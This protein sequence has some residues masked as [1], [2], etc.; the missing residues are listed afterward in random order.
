MGKNFLLTLNLRFEKINYTYSKKNQYQFL[1]SNG[2]ITMS[3]PTPHPPTYSEIIEVILDPIQGPLS[4]YWLA[5]QILQNR[6]SKAKNP[7]KAALNQIQQERGRLLVYLQPD[8]ILPIRLALQGARFRHRLNHSIIRK[9]LLELETNLVYYLPRFFPIEQIKL[10]DKQKTPIPFELLSIPI[11]KNSILGVSEFTQKKA[12]LGR[13]LTAQNAHPKDHL[14]FTLLDWENGVFQLD[15]EPAS[16][17]DRSLLKERNQQLADIFWNLLEGEKY[18]D[19]INYVAVPSAY[20][21]LPDKGG[22]PRDHW[23]VV[24]ENDER[25]VT[26]GWEIRYS[27]AQLP[28]PELY[29]NQESGKRVSTETEKFT[30]QQ[31]QQ[32]YRLKIALVYQ[33][34]IWRRIEIQ[35]HHTLADLDDT[36]REAFNHDVFDHLG[37]FWKL[38]ARSGRKRKRYREVDLGHVYPGGQDG[39]GAK[40]CIA[41]IGLQVGDRMK[42]VYDFGDWIEHLIILEAIDEPKQNADY[43]REIK[44]NKPKYVHCVECLKEGIETNAEWICLTCSNEKQIDLVLCEGCMEK[45]NDEHYIVEIIY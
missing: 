5:E 10:V 37:G 11:Q 26:N 12:N 23:Q 31:G 4:V 7:H 28:F 34:R 29:L 16:E 38:V 17:F 3:N 15:I 13:W 43:P 20:A 41:E 2:E 21:L 44:R 27:D 9:G 45:H 22:F 1:S 40:T 14:L 24:I 33:R 19:I 30:K 18:E 35:G 32:V 8:T 42:Y 36:I 39:D 6:P 25:M